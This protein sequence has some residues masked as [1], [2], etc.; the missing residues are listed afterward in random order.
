[1]Q[2][3]IP[4][5]T[6]AWDEARILSGVPACGAELTEA[7]NPLEAGLYHTVSLAKGCYLGQETIAKVY[8]TKGAWPALLLSRFQRFADMLCLKHM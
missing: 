7:Y 3:A 8:N 1:M 2:G 6:E 4:M 5:G